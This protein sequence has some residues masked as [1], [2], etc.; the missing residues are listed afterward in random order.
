M[1]IESNT[2]FAI[3]PYLKSYAPVSIRGIEFKPS[4]LVD[5]DTAL[6]EEER[7]HLNALSSVFY[8]QSDV[9]STSM[10]Y[11]VLRLDSDSNKTDDLLER[12]REVRILLGY[13]Y[14]SPHHP[15]G[16]P[17]YNYE[18]ADLYLLQPYRVMRSL[19]GF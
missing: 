4:Q 14:A 8:L 5:E 3:F 13:I 6:S 19:L 1:R 16:D 18:F 17:F 12:L 10:M 7:S 15:D 2:L 9:R 11:A